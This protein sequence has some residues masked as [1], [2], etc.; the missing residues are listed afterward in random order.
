MG[1][2]LDLVRKVSEPKSTGSSVNQE[3]FKREFNQLASHLRDRDYSPDNFTKLQTLSL[4]MD[5]AWNRLDFHEFKKVID[6]MM[7]IPGLQA[8]GNMPVGTKIFSHILQDTVWVAIDPIFQANDGILVYYPEEIQNLK[9]AT[10]DEVQ[11]V[12][13]VKKELG[14]KLIAVNQKG[15]G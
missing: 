12:H 8:E 6:E 9:G 7:Q 2:Y 1:R 3:T 15:K 14:G 13:R 4:E 5:A 10:P 11:A